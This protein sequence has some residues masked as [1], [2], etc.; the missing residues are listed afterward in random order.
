[1]ENP[2]MGPSPP[3]SEP[4]STRLLY[5]TPQEAFLVLVITLVATLMLG[6]LLLNVGKTGVYL[7]E[8]L[9]LIPPLFFLRFKGF[10]VR[11]CLRWNGVSPSV[12]ISTMLIGIALIVLLDEMDRLVNMIYPMPENLQQL[13]TGFTEMKTWTDYLVAG[14]GIVLL[15]A[16]CEESLFRGF[17]QVSFEAH[18]TIT[19]AVLISALL[20]AL[21]HF[22]PWWMMQILILGVF[23]GFISWRCD[24]SLPGMV[25]HGLNNGLALFIGR[26]LEANGKFAWYRWGEH[27]SPALLI[28]AAALLFLGLKWFI[29]LTPTSSLESAIQHETPAS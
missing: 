5:P 22:N 28:A 21:A 2:N 7:A 4:P 9:F 25:I 17:L 14:V 23:L 27:V 12:F 15:A 24:S 16:I 10:E 3:A 18:G 11:R 8:L 26:S 6:A 19:R 13:L 20:F 29:R 1:M